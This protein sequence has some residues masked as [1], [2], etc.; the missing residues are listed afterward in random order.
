MV[1]WV[2]QESRLEWVRFGGLLDTARRRRVLFGGIACILAA[3]LSSFLLLHRPGPS[4]PGALL[5]QHVDFGD[6]PAGGLRD[7]SVRFSS[8]PHGWPGLEPLPG[9]LIGRLG[10]AKIYAAP[11]RAGYC[12]MFSGR[13]GPVGGCLARPAPGEGSSYRGAAG[14]F[15][16]RGVFNV[17]FGSTLVTP[18]AKVFVLYADGSHQ[19]LPV[20]WVSRPI[21]AGFYYTVI[22]GDH[23]T[24]AHGARAVVAVRDGT[25]VARQTLPAPRD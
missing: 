23:R 5:G 14:G 7:E 15:S 25:V 22:P 13:S 18:G 9:R 3:G 17:V 10:G 24:R 20:I 19:R 4:R 1:A 16:R 2:R 8:L 21:R 6:E 11:T 12:E